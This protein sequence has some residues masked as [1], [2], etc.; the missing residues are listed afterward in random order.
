[1][2]CCKATIRTTGIKKYLDVLSINCP[3][4]GVS[5]LMLWE[6]LS[7]QIIP[8]AMP[9]VALLLVGPP[10]PD[11]SK[12]MTQTKRDTLVLQVG[13]YAKGQ[14]PI[15]VKNVFA[16]KSQRRNRIGQYIDGNL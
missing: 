14:F 7:G 11:R 9:A 2:K 4:E 13:S 3:P 10:L 8:R 16:K 15:H 6:G 5:T 1:V 12:V